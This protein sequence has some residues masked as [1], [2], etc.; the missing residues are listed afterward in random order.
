MRNH[1]KNLKRT[2]KGAVAVLACLLMIA[3]LGL[4]A[5]AV[6]LGYLANSQTE[7]QRTADAAALAACAQL[8]YSPTPGAP[9]DTAYNAQMA[10]GVAA[11]YAAA[12]K[13]CGASPT[14]SS[15]D[16]VIGYMANP[17]QQ[18]TIQTGGDANQYN[19]VQVTVRRSASENGL[20]PSI[21]GKIFGVTGESTSATAT[22]A[23]YNNFNG[24]GIPSAVPP[25]STQSTPSLMFLPYALDQASWT[26]LLAGT[27]SDSFSYCPNSNTVSSGSDGILE[28]N[29][30]P[31]GTGSPGN[32]GTVLVGGNGTSTLVRQIE[33]GLLPSDLSSFGGK[34]QLD[35]T[36]NLYLPAKPG[37]SA[38]TKD[39]LASIIGQVRIIPIF[40]SISGNGGNATYDI[41]GFGGVRVMDVCLTGSM[42]SKHLTVQ[43]APIY[44]LG[45]LSAGGSGGSST[46][47]NLNGVYSPVFLVH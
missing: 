11:Q 10:P 29:L 38:G 43:P 17:S 26:A 41:V 33:N 20:V 19:A 35:G 44:S 46:A 47:S 23:F 32:R 14:L 5:F 30:F 37:I 12:N 28:V 39:A 9:V 7:L 40:A 22:A 25:G 27:G 15:S 36:G 2:R 6:D 1:T 3:M 18:G 4:L 31:Q 16:V 42:S 8:V 45:A 21:F 13:V 24:F 34:L